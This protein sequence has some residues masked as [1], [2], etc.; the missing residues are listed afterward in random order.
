MTKREMMRYERRERKKRKRKIQIRVMLVLL[1]LVFCAAGSAAFLYLSG[2]G[3][4]AKIQIATSDQ[5]IY[6]GDEIPPLLMQ[7]S[8]ETEKYDKRIRLDRDKHFTAQD[9]IRQLEKGKGVSVECDADIQMEGTYPIRIKLDGGLQEKLKKEWGNKAEISIKEGTLTVKNR[10]GEWEGNR[11]RRYDGTYVT[12]DFVTYQKKQYYFD[13]E[14][15][16][17]TGWKKINDDTYY[18]GQEGVMEKETWEDGEEGKFY[19]DSEG[20]AVK[21]WKE[22]EGNRYFFDQEGKMAVG[23]VR[24]GLAV[25]SFDHDGKLLSVKE[26]KVDP[27][28]PMVALTFDDGPGKR[29]G[30]ILDQLKKYGAHATFFMLGQNVPSYPSVVQKM[31]DLGCELG[32]HSYDHAELTKLSP[33]NI[34]SEVSRTNDSIRSAAGVNPTVMRPPYGAVNR[35]VSANVGMPMILWN[36]DTLDW[37]T[38][39]A[40]KTIDT[41]MGSVKDG[42]VILMHDIHTE[43]VDAALVLIPKL[44]E[45]GFQ[46]V[47]VSELAAAKN[48]SLAAG[49]TYTDF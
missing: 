17:T 13:E 41:V 47:T 1:L 36:I 22:I 16:K 44:Q 23:D 29:T 26:D 6:E 38:R 39:N 15:N 2:Y 49:K 27:A 45:A 34:A 43:S 21:G 14:G 10:V 8:S 18:F 20:H 33:G 28:K 11:F 48:V 9:L 4:K 30:E 7:V 46:L 5:E 24:M 35:T 12:N 3:R 32:N 40:Q 19:L 42:D 37:K 25:Y 31:K